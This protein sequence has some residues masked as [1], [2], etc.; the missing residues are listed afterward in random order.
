[1]K[2]FISW[3]GKRSHMLASTLRDWLPLV[4]HY[5]QPWVSEGDIDAGGRWALE[6]AQE[7]EAADFGVICLTRENIA[8]PW[9]LFEAGSLA[10]SLQHGIVVPFLLDLDLSEISGPLAQFQAKKVDRTATAELVQAINR[11][12]A[13]PVE[14]TRLT[15][16]FEALWPQFE[17]RLHEIPP[18]PDEAGPA[19]AS[20][21]VLEDLVATVRSIDQRM[22]N[23]E[24]A[25]T[26][27]LVTLGKGGQEDIALMLPLLLPA[28]ERQHLLNLVNG[29][30]T[31]YKG[32]PEVRGELRR[33]RSLGLLRMRRDRQVAQ[34]Q[35][36]LG[37]DL[38]DYIELTELGKRW[39]RKLQEIEKAE[40]LD[41]SKIVGPEAG[42]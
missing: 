23:L 8:S 25:Y 38:A 5:I 4:L 1:M 26:N 17:V 36:G 20:G 14:A 30:T 6:L 16:L 3:S 40:V 9:L 32:D 15:Q 35:D 24:E 34:M 11:A 29:W 28:A 42:Y 7:L 18:R 22:R 41:D 21:E 12:S 39:V 37:F 19:R 31:E 13:T 10:K 33:L 27:R 2:L